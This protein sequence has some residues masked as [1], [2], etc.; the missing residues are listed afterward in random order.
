MKDL[1]TCAMEIG[2]Q[3]LISG[4][5]VHRAE[6]SMERICHAFGAVRVDVFIIPSSMVVTVRCADGSLYTQT[7]RVHKIGTDFHR[8]DKLNDL[9]RRICAK[10][11]TLEEIRAELSSLQKEKSYSFWVQTLA[12]A[13][14]AA[15][16]SVFFGGNLVQC[17]IAFLIGGFVNVISLFSDKIFKNQIFSKF[18]SAF[19]ITALAFVAVKLGVIEKSDEVIIGNIML[20]IMGLGF[21]NA[22]R[23]LFVGD[24][25]AGILRCLEALLTAI[26]IA[27]GYFLFV[28]VTGGNAI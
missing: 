18:L 19:S 17:L 8:L 23:D 26:A 24:S 22:L 6:D 21:T 27:A 4:A 10:K 28:F 15:A 7:R 1:L 16:F 14:I 9:S 12:H 20:L 5:E 13:L 11:L 3:M 25:I 2:E